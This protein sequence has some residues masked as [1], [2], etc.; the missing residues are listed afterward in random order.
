M[1][2]KTHLDVSAWTVGGTDFI[3]LFKNASVD[4]EAMTQ[5]GR[6]VSQRYGLAIPVK[7]NVSFSF[8]ELITSSGGG[9]IRQSNLNITVFSIGGTS[10]LGTLDSGSLKIT[11]VCKD[12]SADPDEWEFNY[13]MGT[14]YEVE[15]ELFVATSATLLTAIAAAGITG[16]LVAVSISLG[17]SVV[18]LPMTLTK[19]SHTT[20]EGEFQKQ[21]VSLKGRGAP[22]T[23]TGN[24]LVVSILTGT[25]S[26]AYSLNTGANTY[27][28]DAIVKE[29]GF[30]W[31]NSQ[32]ITASHA[33]AGSGAPTVS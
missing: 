23:A 12:G 15:A 19:G 21:K 20:G 27:A 1:A 31:A 17:G 26:I 3:G 8:D 7:K 33:F 18:A 13:A 14:E 25:A 6:A 11:T 2:R 24:P 30:T 22:T 4:I 5:E 16:L 28:G 32:L 29:S 9:A 10:Y